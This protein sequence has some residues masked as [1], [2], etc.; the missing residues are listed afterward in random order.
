MNAEISLKLYEL[1]Q[2]FIKDNNKAKLFVSKIEETIE[3]KFDDKSKYLTNKTDLSELETKISN[4]IYMV[5][6]IQFLA[7]VGSI[8]AI[9]NFMLK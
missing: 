4:R 9:I 5:G 7:I 6:L 3:A 1:T 8:L 2:E